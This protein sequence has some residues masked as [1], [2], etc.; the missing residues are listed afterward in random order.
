MWRYE[1]GSGIYK[2]E[3]EGGHLDRDVNL[4]IVSVWKVSKTPRQDEVSKSQGIRVQLCGKLWDP[5]CL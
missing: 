2:S 5:V 4:G 3:T 1:A